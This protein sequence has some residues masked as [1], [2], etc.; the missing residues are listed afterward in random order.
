MK[1]NDLMKELKKDVSF[2]IKLARE[3]LE[4]ERVEA[5]LEAVRRD[6]E[7]L[8]KECQAIKERL[9]H[10]LQ[11][12]FIRGFDE[13]IWPTGKYKKDIREA[14]K[15]CFFDEENILKFYYCESEDEYLIGQRIDNFYYAKF[16]GVDWTWCMSRYLPWGE[17]VVNPNTSWKEYTYPSEPK[18]MFFTEWLKGFCKKW[19]GQAPADIRGDAE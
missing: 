2:K 17:H 16:N 11:S 10:L 13:V 9:C 15:K 12:D 7:E 1:N 18:V 4:K 3:L 14:D 19:Y 6:N 5:E 8:R